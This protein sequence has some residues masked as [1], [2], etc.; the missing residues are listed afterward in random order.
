M[1][2]ETRRRNGFYIYSMYLYHH[3][4]GNK[5]V[6]RTRWTY[7]TVI[8]GPIR[9]RHIADAQKVTTFII[10]EAGFQ[11]QTHIHPSPSPIKLKLLNVNIIL[12]LLP[13]PVLL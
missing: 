5:S 10:I 2:D 13:L 9:P 12:L 8:Q 4:Q 3:E 1:T 6:I 11:E 7:D